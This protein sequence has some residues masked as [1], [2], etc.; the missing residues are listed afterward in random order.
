PGEGLF[1]IGNSRQEDAADN[2]VAVRTITAQ[3]RYSG[4]K[5]N[6]ALQAGW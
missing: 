1:P 4:V 6:H 2:R 3:G 5:N